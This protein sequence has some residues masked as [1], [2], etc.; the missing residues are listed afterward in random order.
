M[1]MPH[2]DDAARQTA[3]ISICLHQ[4]THRATPGITLPYVGLGVNQQFREEDDY[5]RAVGKVMSQ[6]GEPF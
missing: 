5:D 2:D 6:S 1:A 3:F 4:Q